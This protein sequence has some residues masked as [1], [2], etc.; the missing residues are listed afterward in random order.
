M[1]KQAALPTSDSPAPVYLNVKQ[2]ASYLGCTISAV[3]HQL[4]YARAVPFAIMGKRIIFAR[5]DL[6]SYMAKLKKAAT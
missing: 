2:A 3:R 1:K 6:D 4:V 5:V